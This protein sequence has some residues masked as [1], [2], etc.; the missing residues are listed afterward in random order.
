MV[1]KFKNL[2]CNDKFLPFASYMKGLLLKGLKLMMENSTN[3]SRPVAD[4][5]FGSEKISAFSECWKE[6]ISECCKTLSEK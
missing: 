5:L 2:V 6:V 3:A 1:N 4:C